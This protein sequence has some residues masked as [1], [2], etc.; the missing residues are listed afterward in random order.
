MIKLAQ[1][2]DLILVVYKLKRE[3]RTREVELCRYHN[4]TEKMPVVI[5]HPKETT[6]AQQPLSEN[7]AHSYHST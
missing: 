1:S 5:P 3:E 6:A 7:R 4:D 2:R